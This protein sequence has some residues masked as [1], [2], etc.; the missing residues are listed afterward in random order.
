MKI[1][2]LAAAISLG[3]CA[4]GMVTGSVAIDSDGKIEGTIGTS[5]V[6]EPSPFQI[7]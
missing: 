6:L 3:A 7:Q 2:I 5:I 4:Q 1:I